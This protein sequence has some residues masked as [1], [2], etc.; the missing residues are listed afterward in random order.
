[1]FQGHSEGV[2]IVRVFA[3]HLRFPIPELIII[4]KMDTLVYDVYCF[5]RFIQY[6]VSLSRIGKVPIKKNLNEFFLLH[7][8]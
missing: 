5:K 6:D 3:T 8:Y 2:I 4:I 1:M 7:L